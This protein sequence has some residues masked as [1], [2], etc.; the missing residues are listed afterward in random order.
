MIKIAY[1]LFG[2]PKFHSLEHRLFNTV[3]LVNGTLNIFGVI[4]C[5]LSRKLRSA[6][7]FESNLRSNYAFYVL[8][9]SCKKYLLYTVLAIQSYDFNLSICDVVL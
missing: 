6:S 4:W 9:I 8:F 3:A 1:F 5:C 7:C 2:N